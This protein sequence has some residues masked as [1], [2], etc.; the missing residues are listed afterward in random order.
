MEQDTKH[1]RIHGNVQGVS[2]RA[3]TKELAER[4]L[5]TGWVRNVRKDK[6][7]EALVTGHEDQVQKFIS[8]LYKGPQTANISAIEVNDGVDEEL[9]S[10]EI[11]DTV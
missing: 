4:M 11:R 2:Y 3:W 9:K 1:L 7:V 6:S 8:A 10:F 5:L